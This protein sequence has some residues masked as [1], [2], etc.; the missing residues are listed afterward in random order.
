MSAP[1]IPAP[2]ITQAPSRLAPASQEPP[3]TGAVDGSS[4]SLS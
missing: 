1:T 2:E 3:A 4:G